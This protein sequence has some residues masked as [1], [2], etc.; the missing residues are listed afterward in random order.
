MRPP[1]RTARPPCP[2]ARVREALATSTLLRDVASVR[3]DGG[4]AFAVGTAR[5]RP[6]YSQEVDRLEALGNTADDWSRVRVADG[7][8]W[9]HVRHCH[10][11]GDVLIG[12]LAG[13][14][15]VAGARF[16][17]GVYHSTVVNCVLG[18]DVLVREV[19]L[20]AN[21]VLGEAAVLFDCGSVVCDAATAFGNGAALPLGPE[22]G[23]RE[24][25]VY[26]E[27]D[28]ATAAAIARSR[29][30]PDLLARYAAAVAEYADRARSPRGIIGPGASLCH[31]PRVRNVYVGAGARV[32]GA[33][34]VEDSTLL[35]DPD[36]PARVESGACVSGSLLQWGSRASTL[37]LV[38]RAVLAE[39]AHAE[40]HA[41]VSD[42]IVGCNSG[43]A[44]GEVTA[45]LVGPFV[46]L[47]H[48]ALL[49]A[50]LWPEGKGN[51]SYGA[52][53]G[54]NHTGK[55]PDQ[56][57]LPG[58]GLFLGLGV[59]V[60]YP[61][62]FSRSPYTI[63]A[64]GV[65]TL[66]QRLAFPFSLVNLPAAHLPN[67]SPAYNQL[68]PAW[69]LTDN[70]YAVRRNEAKFRARNLARRTS[71]ETEVFRPAIVELMRDAVRRLEAVPP[72]EVYTERDVEGLGKN[73][74]LEADRAAAVEAYR[75]FIRYYAL[76]GLSCR[77]REALA[78]G[79]GGIDRLLTMRS[80][81]QPWEHQRRIL[82]E[83]FG[84]TDVAAA[85]RDLPDVLERVARGVELSKGKDDHRGRKVISDYADAHV[86]AAGDP[87][88]RQ[89][90]DETARQRHEV[91]LL[92]ERLAS[93]GKLAV[94]QPVRLADPVPVAFPSVTASG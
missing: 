48:Q 44:A 63:L 23:G 66:P 62:D 54:S 30:R 32:E 49:I 88:V 57:F 61:A 15:E 19:K 31:T 43:V 71:L 79:A 56:E 93:W 81:A 21:Y 6:L 91:E 92:L 34:L 5:V 20:L 70:L 73:Y 29:H 72:R 1:D 76:L 45:S 74:L 50:A 33:T 75:F 94:A 28:V 85:L 39:H 2:V 25:P 17:V 77:V 53:V 87:F 59:N 55:A 18:N 11:G 64:C 89:T 80:A 12:R 65:T 24:V 8:D 83:D 14:V 36:E 82:A 60:K 4:R 86:P 67:V 46:S 7:F 69:L 38:S 58:E 35:G 52:N 37:A 22:T 84:C 10:F 51:V 9:R 41:K 47:H 16:P 40:R 26:A 3:E 13:H 68:V 90:W 42:S 27:I 78:R